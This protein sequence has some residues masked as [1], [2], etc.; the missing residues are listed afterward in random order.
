MVTIK[1]VVR[2]AAFELESGAYK[3]NG[4]AR[5]ADDNTILSV[6]GTLY[7]E[8]KYAGNFSSSRNEIE[9][10]LKLNISGVDAEH[11]AE[12]A[13]VVNGVVADIVAQYK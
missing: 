3:G 12:V 5:I 8:G 9:S 2:V 11:I 1:N 6:N 10:A 4:E 13:E 7:A